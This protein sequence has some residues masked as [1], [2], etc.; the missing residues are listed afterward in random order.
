MSML[1][2]P[3]KPKCSDL[4]ADCILRLNG[5]HKIIQHISFDKS[6]ENIAKI[7]RLKFELD[8]LHSGIQTLFEQ[9]CFMLNHISNGTATATVETKET[10]SQTDE[11]DVQADELQN[12]E[13]F[14]NIEKYGMVILR[15]SQEKTKLLC[16]DNEKEQIVRL[17]CHEN[18]MTTT[19]NV[20][21]DNAIKNDTSNFASVYFLQQFN[22]MAQLRRGKTHFQLN[23]LNHIAVSYEME[24]QKLD[25]KLQKSIEKYTKIKC[26]V[27]ILLDII[28]HLKC[29]LRLTYN[30]NQKAAKISDEPTTFDGTSNEI[31][32]MATESLNRPI[33]NI[34]G[35][36]IGSDSISLSKKQIEL[37]DKELMQSNNEFENQVLV[38]CTT[39]HQRGLIS[40]ELDFKKDKT[41]QKSNQ[42]ENIAE[43]DF[44]RIFNYRLNGSEILTRAKK[45]NS[46]ELKIVLHR[47]VDCKCNFPSGRRKH[48]QNNVKMV[49]NF[50][51]AGADADVKKGVENKA[52]HVFK[53]ET[54]K[55]VLT[56]KKRS[57]GK[58]NTNRAI[59][60]GIYHST[61]QTNQQNSLRS[62]RTR[63]TIS[64]NAPDA[65]VKVTLV[66]KKTIIETDTK[67]NAKPKLKT[68]A[69]HQINN[70]KQTPR[71]VSVNR[72]ISNS[73]K[74]TILQTHHSRT[75]TNQTG[76]PVASTMTTSTITIT[77]QKPN[78]MSTNF[79]RATKTKPIANI[80]P[81]KAEFSATDRKLTHD[82]VRKKY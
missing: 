65:G 56:P 61:K 67:S 46:K 26:C 59:Q 20:P 68:L 30:N 19:I 1:T 58:T 75:P 63:K 81:R 49:K 76:R 16:G 66:G 70:I 34:S 80:P 78:A 62:G 52:L 17:L 12:T 31:E 32:N 69:K 8:E 6:N 13:P 53:P 36:S 60:A 37:L 39:C 24:I 18:E 44:C 77:T 73:K 27:V 4:V 55:T 43:H 74:E 51:A 47:K 35:K 28:D 64:K 45:S 57:I 79:Q 71:V 23:K 25:R 15:S 9:L 48:L 3:R 54:N 22:G 29:K 42:G 21:I 38:E 33:S 50:S 7:Q 10:E 14:P 40:S 82:G 11:F 72:K 2:M 41:D 5:L